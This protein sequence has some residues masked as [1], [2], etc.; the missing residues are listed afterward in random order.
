MCQSL[1]PEPPEP[2][3]Q[4]RSLA[5]QS[6]Q[7]QHLPPLPQVCSTPACSLW[8]GLDICLLSGTHSRKADVCPCTHVCTTGARFCMPVSVRGAPPP[9]LCSLCR[10]G[11]ARGQELQFRPLRPRRL[12]LSCRDPSDWS[13]IIPAFLWWREKWG[14]VCG[15]GAEGG[16]RAQHSWALCPADS[17][18]DADGDGAE[19]GMEGAPG[20]WPMCATR[21]H[22]H[23]TCEGG[24]GA[25]LGV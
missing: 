14:I 10:A 18:M 16:R 22:A 11:T 20:P 24:E 17:W 9:T 25:G 3:G 12:M 23:A 7:P 6:C 2:C 4:G 21:I 8:L 15:L 19:R 13:L 5:C 1:S